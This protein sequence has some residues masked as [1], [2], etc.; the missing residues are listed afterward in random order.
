[1]DRIFIIVL[2]LGMAICVGCRTDAN[3]SIGDCRLPEMLGGIEKEFLI[4]QKEGCSTMEIEFDEII[5][6][7]DEAVF[8]GRFVGPPDRRFKIDPNGFVRSLACTVLSNELI[9]GPFRIVAES[10]FHVTSPLPED[11]VYGATRLFGGGVNPIKFTCSYKGFPSNSVKKSSKSQMNL[12]NRL[13]NETTV[14]YLIKSITAVR[15][16]DCDYGYPYEDFSWINIKGTG[17]CKLRVV[18]GASEGWRARRESWQMGAR[19]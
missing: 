13:P 16:N 12:L 7:N 10:E 9:D 2:L 5:L 19:D 3:E 6:S 17:E 14:K 8:T 18:S 11:M 4:Y 1:M 15:F